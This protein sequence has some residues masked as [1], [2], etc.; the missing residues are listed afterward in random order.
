[1]KALDSHFEIKIFPNRLENPGSWGKLTGVEKPRLSISI[2]MRKKK[3]GN[4]LNPEGKHNP[5]DVSNPAGKGKQTYRVL[6]K[7][8]VKEPK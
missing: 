8:P 7:M 6:Y 4:V 3:N 5:E 2:L 1:M